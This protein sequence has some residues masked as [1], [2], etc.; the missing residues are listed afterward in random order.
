[1]PLWRAFVNLDGSRDERLGSRFDGRKDAAN[2]SPKSQPNS[3]SSRSM[4]LPRQGPLCQFSSRQRRSPQLFLPYQMIL[5]GAGLLQV[6]QDRAVTRP[7]FRSWLP[8][9]LANGS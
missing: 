3:F 8:I 4:S 1:M 6:F 2:V 7:A 5:L 9:L